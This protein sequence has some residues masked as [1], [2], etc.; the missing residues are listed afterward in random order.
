[1]TVEPGDIEPGIYFDVPFE[2]YLAWPLINNTLLTHAVRSMAHLRVAEQSPLDQPTDSMRLGSLIHSGVLE[3]DSLI[4][5]PRFEDEIRRKDGREYANPKA[6]SEYKQRVADF[7]SAN[8]GKRIVSAVEFESIAGIRESLSRHERAAEHLDEGPVEVSI[9]WDDPDS[10]IRCKGRLDK[11]C[12]QNRRIVDLKTTRDASDFER[13]L[14]KYGYHRQA[15]FYSDGMSILTGHVH[16]FAIVAVETEPPYCVRGAPVSTN[17]LDS[18]RKEYR[19]LLQDIAACRTT[20]E[21]PA[22]EDPERWELPK[23]F[24]SHESISLSVSGQTVTL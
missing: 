17:A 7:E 4:V 22:Y 23:W 8:V 1:V 2:E 18:G 10:G 14:L 16:E 11:W 9:V 15:A 19:R 13:S 12:E 24:Q 21:W 20:G 5:M 3:P 6:T